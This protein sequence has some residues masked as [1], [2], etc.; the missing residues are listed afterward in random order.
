MG[1]A[2][3]V[4]QP[5]CEALPVGYAIGDGVIITEVLEA[6]PGQIRQYLA[7]R[8]VDD[9]TL[10]VRAALPNTA[11]ASAL[12]R[13][14]NILCALTA[15][16]LEATSECWETVT[17][18]FLL[19]EALAG[20][21]LSEAWHATGISETQHLDWLIQ[22]C[23]TLAKLHAQDIVYLAVHPE[24]LRIMNGRLVL[25]DFS[26]ARQ[27]PLAADVRLTSFEYY[28]APEISLA[29]QQV[30]PSTDIY[31]FGATW[32]A[33]LLN[34]PL[35][36]EHFESP[37]FV[38]PPLDFLP[39]LAPGV[40]R[41]IYKALQRLPEQRHKSV[42]YVRDA[43]VELQAQSQVQVYPT[44]GACSDTGMVRDAN[45]DTHLVEEYTI[46]ESAKALRCGFY[47]ISDGMGGEAGGVIASQLTAHEV[48][49]AT[50]P[51]LRAYTFQETERDLSKQIMPLLQEAINRASASVYQRAREESRLRRM[52]A[53][54]VVAVL[55][56]QQLFVANVGDSRAYLINQG[57]S[58]RLTQDHT[59]VAE[60]IAR[61][62]L[63]LQDARKH[64][65]RG[66]LTRNIGGR[67]NTE[68]HF[69]QRE[70]QP[71]DKLLLCCDGLTDVLEDTEIARIVLDTPE[72]QEACQRLVNE[73][74]LRGGPDNISV[75]LMTWTDQS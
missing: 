70:L 7:Q 75:I 24:S 54:V 62:E 19:R 1:V 74:N 27:L 32:Y 45:E 16:G 9:K 10:Y 53:T 58:V 41:I 17:H 29:P 71:G 5:E 4:A 43:L 64:P 14:H 38:K 28:S 39:E 67:P 60:L 49:A 18:I 51:V 68:A 13:E 33:L 25:A 50:L 69:C 3:A 40:N 31:G 47:L 26:C 65:A 11:A 21:P 6:L 23:D 15:A 22:L 30:S 56:G 37:F 8:E 36:Q 20:A 44:V 12:R 46:G 35:D 73:A 42:W 57:G 59:V 48:A 72:P 66:Q 61:G 55:L 63:D 2:P 34:T 52:G